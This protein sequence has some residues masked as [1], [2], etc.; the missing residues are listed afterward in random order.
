MTQT[1]DPLHVLLVEDS[2]NDAVLIERHL[3]GAGTE[4]LPRRIEV[5]HEQRLT[6]A[7][8]VIEA[9]DIDLVLLDLGLPESTGIETFEQVK[10]RLTDIPVIVLTG[11]RDEEAAVNV[12]KQGAQDYLNKGSIDR[13]QLIKSI[14]YALER[15]ERESE[16]RQ[17]TEQLEVLNR[18]LRHDLQNDIQVLIGWLDTLRAEIDGDN[19]RLESALATVEHMQEMTENTKSYMDLIAGNKDISLD[20]VRLDDILEAE[21]EK[22]M[23]SYPNAAFTIPPSIP[24]ITVRANGMLSSVFRNL[25]KNAITH[26]DKE[27]PEIEIGIKIQPETVIVLIGDNGPGIPDEEKDRLFGKGAQGSDSSGTGIGLYLVETLVT[28]FDGGIW[29]EDNE[30][31]GTIFC[32]QLPRATDE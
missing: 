14:R 29:I 25:L 23:S 20:L 27:T 6:D 9:G 30:P 12:L 13:E 26:N 5:Q 21:Y 8:A 19:N 31:T 24:E 11:L 32:V 10:D 16:L 1:G 4:L 28:E 18:I 22:A 15:Q 2:P 7:L 17:T 3:S